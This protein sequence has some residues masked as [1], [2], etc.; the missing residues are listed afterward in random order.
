MLKFLK[1][2]LVVA[3][4][5][6]STS[7][8]GQSAEG[9]I[10][11]NIYRLKESTMSGGSGLNVKLFINDKEVTSIMSNT[12]LIYKMKTAGSTKIK[13]A[14]EFGG[15]PIGSPYVET[16]DLSAGTEY[17]ISINA[18]SMFGVKGSIVD[19]NDLK[20]LAKNKYNDTI[21]LEEGK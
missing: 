1:L 6:L 9:D 8:I 15:S 4:F 16:M 20:K 18:G 11:L 13:F 5:G 2:G 12:K 14:A 10:T 17:H 19:A 3:F 7:L 21:T